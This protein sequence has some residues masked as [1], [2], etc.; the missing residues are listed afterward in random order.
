[1][2][3]LREISAAMDILGCHESMKYTFFEDN[4]GAFD[5]ASTL[6]VRPWTKCVAITH[7]HFYT[8][9]QQKDMWIVKVNATKQEAIFLTKNL[10]Q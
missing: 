2:H 4:N 7:C 5:L 9:F 1:M 8:C 6:S 3:L 10:V